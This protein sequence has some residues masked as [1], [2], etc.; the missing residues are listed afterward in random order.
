MESDICICL[1]V[2]EERVD[3]PAGSEDDHLLVLLGIQQLVILFS[4]GLIEIPDPFEKFRVEPLRAAFTHIRPDCAVG[5]Q[6]P[7]GY[8][9]Q[10]GKPGKIQIDDRVAPLQSFGQGAVIVTV[11][12]PAVFA[13]FP[14]NDPV[15]LFPGGFHPARLPE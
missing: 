8:T 1:Q 10:T 5:G 14:L 4:F 3:F 12:D 2:F 9:P 6:D 11:D 15:D 13:D 7:L